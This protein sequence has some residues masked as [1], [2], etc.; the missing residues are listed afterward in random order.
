M[1]RELDGCKICGLFGGPHEDHA[2]WHGTSIG[3]PASTPA[4]EEIRKQRRVEAAYRDVTEGDAEVEEFIEAMSQPVTGDVVGGHWGPSPREWNPTGTGGMRGYKPL[5]VVADEIHGWLGDPESAIG[6]VGVSPVAP[7]WVYAP[8]AERGAVPQEPAPDDVD[9][10]LTEALKF[11]YVGQTVRLTVLD[12]GTGERATFSV[13]KRSEP[14]AETER[15]DRIREL[16]TKIRN[17]LQEG[18]R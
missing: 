3:K 16:E 14:D 10:L 7:G 8:Q 1:S 2:G 18:E 11:A 15:R 6:D 13:I 4:W 12:R 5:G 9:R 17:D